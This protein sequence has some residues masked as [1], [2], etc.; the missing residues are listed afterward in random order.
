MCASAFRVS[1]YTR[2]GA[3]YSVLWKFP[4]AEEFNWMSRC[5]ESPLIE[6]L[7]SS[8]AACAHFV[9]VV[10]PVAESLIDVAIVPNFRA[11]ERCD[12]PRRI[13]SEKMYCRRAHRHNFAAAYVR[14]NFVGEY[15]C[16]R[17]VG[18]TL[19]SGPTYICSAEWIQ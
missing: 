6:M 19:K 7:R 13:R 9:A 10:R 16:K 14:I 12:G 5:G 2:P 1:M 15:C 11:S 3:R 8:L 18:C 4:V 17:I